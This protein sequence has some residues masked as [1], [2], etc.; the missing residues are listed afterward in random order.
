MRNDNKVYVATCIVTLA[1]HGAKSLKDK[2]AALNRIKTR[3][4]NE[5]NVSIAEVGDPDRR[6][7]AQL[8][9]VSIS[10]DGIYVEGQMRKA[11][12]FIAGLTQA[13]I[14]DVQLGVEI[15]GY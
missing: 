12:S 1:L 5:F 8:G 11:V 9:L 13:E 7:T 10:G 15:K 6:Q 2:R 3:V 4:T 14:A